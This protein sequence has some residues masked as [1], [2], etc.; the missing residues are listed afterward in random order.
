MLFVHRNFAGT[1]FNKETNYVKKVEGELG[2]MVK[3]RRWKKR[4]KFQVN[5]KVLSP[6][7]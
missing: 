2:E 6:R 7:R 4:P 3:L 5:F 1:S